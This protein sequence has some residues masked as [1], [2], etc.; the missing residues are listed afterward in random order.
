MK[1]RYSFLFILIFFTL[2]NIFGQDP[3]YSQFYANLLYLNPAF[4]GT[5][6][7]P[8]F[9]LNFRDQW[10]SIPGNFISFSSSYDQYIPIIHGG[11]GVLASAD[12]AG[13]NILQTYNIGGMYNYRVQVS[14]NFNLQFALQGSYLMRSF[15][16]HNLQ[17]ASQILNSDIPIS[18]LPQEGISRLS[19]FD[20][21]FGVMGYTSF[22]YF[23]MAIHHIVPLDLRYLPRSD[24]KFITPWKPRWTAHIGGKITIK[25]TLRDENSFGDIFLYPNLIFISQENFHYMHEGFYF[26]FYPFTVGAWL[27]HDFKSLDAFVIS[28]GVE[29]KSLRIGY[30]YDFSLTELERTGGAHEISLQFIIPCDPDQVKNNK[31]KRKRYAPLSCPYF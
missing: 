1:Q 5:A 8:R 13:G 14:R 12:M 19:R 29:Y 2:S 25:K 15:N 26:N 3:H 18:E 20:A 27:R 31:Q 21:A 16:W 22:L 6:N 11:V 23:G 7:C 9:S 10:P 17:T 30:S 24:G 4:S 28:C